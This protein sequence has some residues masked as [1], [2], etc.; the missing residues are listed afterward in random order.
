MVAVAQ[1]VERQPVE[2][3]VAGSSPVSHPN[4]L[5]SSVVEHELGKFEAPVQFRTEAQKKPIRLNKDNN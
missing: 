3:D 2:L 5:R 1:L 4:R